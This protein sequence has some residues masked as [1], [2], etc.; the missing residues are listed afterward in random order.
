MEHNAYQGLR[1]RRLNHIFELAEILYQ[2]RPEPV[3]RKCK[4]TVVGMALVPRKT[5]QRRGRG[6]RS[7]RSGT[8]PSAQELALA[9]ALKPRKKFVAKTTV[10]A[11]AVGK[12]MFC[13][14]V[15]GSGATCA[16]KHALNLFGSDSSA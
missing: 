6:R 3:V 12:K 2:P 13:T 5:T 16:P 11:K 8:Q 10:G 14:F 7:S 1:H 4:S 15:G 9:K